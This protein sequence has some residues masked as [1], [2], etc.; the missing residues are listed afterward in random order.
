[1][2]LIEDAVACGATR[3]E[4]GQAY[5]HHGEVTAH[6][7]ERDLRRLREKWLAEFRERAAKLCDDMNSEG[8]YIYGDEC[9]KAIRALPLDKEAT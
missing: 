3:A 9:A 1:M 4:P 7:T 2:S 8:D 6:L 5:A